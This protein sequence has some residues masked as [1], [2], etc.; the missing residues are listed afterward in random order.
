MGGGERVCWN[1]TFVERIF[2]ALHHC[3]AEGQRVSLIIME[4]TSELKVMKRRHAATFPLSAL[5]EMQRFYVGQQP[6]DVQSHDG[7][8]LADEHIV[9]LSE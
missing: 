3:L 6:G 5:G 1:R 9:C 8:F 4:I 2:H 7:V